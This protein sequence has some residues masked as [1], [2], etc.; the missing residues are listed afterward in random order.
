MAALGLAVGLLMGLTGL[1]AGSLLTPLLILLAGMSPVTAVGSSLAFSL[2]T[3][4]Y[5]SWAFYRR[6]LVNLRIVREL[7]WGGVAGALAGGVFV[8]YLSRT[9]PRTLEALLPRAIGVVL[10][11]VSAVM[12]LRLL[13]LGKFRAKV[14]PIPRLAEPHRRGLVTLA[15]FGIGTELTVTSIGAGAV[16]APMMSILYKLD[17]GTLVGTNLVVGMVLAAFSLAPRIGLG[18]VEWWSVAALVCGSVPALWLASRLHSRIPRYIPEGMI[19]TALL[20]L[21]LH[22]AWF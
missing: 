21:G 7:S 22:I 3:R 18:V 4:I 14:N 19:A 17:T 12:I 5:G 15:A 20:G 1:G 8:R 2:L 13:P 6:G 9:D 16:M 10:I 11:L